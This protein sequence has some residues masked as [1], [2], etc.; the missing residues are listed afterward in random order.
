MRSSFE[1]AREFKVKV[2]GDGAMPRQV[3]R[4][5]ELHGLDVLS[6]PTWIFD[7][8]KREVPWANREAIRAYQDGDNIADVSST[9]SKSDSVK[10]YAMTDEGG[11][12][13]VHVVGPRRVLLAS[14]R[15][16]NS[17]PAD[18]A[19]GDEPVTLIISPIELVEGTSAAGTPSCS[20]RS[21]S[22]TT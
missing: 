14:M 20:T 22:R 13:T 21:T 9:V 1:R 16:R 17:S 10:F 4:L 18:A 2:V 15:T 7:Q 12:H 3:L 8:D 11:G 5:S 6:T 19:N